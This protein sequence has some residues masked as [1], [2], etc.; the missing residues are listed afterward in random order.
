MKRLVRVALVSFFLCMSLV[1]L[2]SAE[3]KAAV[4]VINYAPTIDTLFVSDKPKIG[5]ISLTGFTPNEGRMKTLYVRGTITDRNRCTDL[6][7][8]EIKVYR[9]G[10]Y[11]TCTQNLLSCY[12]TST[13]I[14]TSC[15]PT[16]DNVAS[17]EASVDIA[18]F[19]DPTD[20]GSE[21]A[22]EYWF[23]E[24]TI[25]D[26][27]LT[28]YTASTHFELNSLAAVEAIQ[29]I[30]YGT[31]ALG[32][33]SNQ[34]AIGLRNAGNRNVQG[35]VRANEDFKSNRKGFKNIPSTQVRI[36]LKDD[37]KWIEGAPI[38]RQD[39]ELPI[40]LSRQ[41]SEKTPLIKN[42]FLRLQ[43]PESAVG[44]TYTNTLTFTAWAY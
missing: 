23:A 6:K 1:R 19:A 16:G 14:F 28:R 11:N 32:K 37:F 44:G 25:L 42:A 35:R 39:I 41:L 27:D 15:N 9:S 7:T 30:S 21:N 5:N 4:P 22:N 2:N 17:F 18:Y 13:S 38:G 26:Q 43:M 20:P 33:I 8:V 31:V 24:A 10:V 3:T 12:A 34:Q 36:S 29:D 40:N